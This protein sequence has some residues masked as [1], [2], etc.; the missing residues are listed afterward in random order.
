M[1]YKTTMMLKN[2]VTSIML[3]SFGG[4]LSGFSMGVVNAP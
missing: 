2:A 1:K 3:I 4:F